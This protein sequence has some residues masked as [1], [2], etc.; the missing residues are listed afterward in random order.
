MQFWSR[1][2]KESGFYLR[3]MYSHISAYDFVLLFMKFFNDLL[4]LFHFEHWDT[5][6]VE[7]ESTD[8]SCLFEYTIEML[9]HGS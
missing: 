2:V 4:Y 5:N 8:M 9:V 6:F 7:N 3:A 1:N